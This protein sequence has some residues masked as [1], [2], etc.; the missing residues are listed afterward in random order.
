M[1]KKFTII[2]WKEKKKFSVF[3]A[4]NCSVCFFIGIESDGHLAQHN[5]YVFSP[6]AWNDF[7]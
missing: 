1:F 6:N 4:K 7:P 3:G 2:R 5:F